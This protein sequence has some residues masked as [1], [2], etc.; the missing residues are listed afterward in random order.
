VQEA[1]G[2]LKILT[3]Q[4]LFSKTYPQRGVLAKKNYKLDFYARST[5]PWKLECEGEVGKT[6]PEVV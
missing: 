3:E 5:I 4:P 6:R 2:V 1:S